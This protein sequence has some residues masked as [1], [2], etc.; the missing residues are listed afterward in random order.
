M[1]STRPRLRFL[2]SLGLCFALLGSA[3]MGGCMRQVKVNPLAWKHVKRGSLLVAK[4]Q[5]DRASAEYSLALEYNP[6]LPEALNGLGL[7][8]FH[9]GQMRLA[10]SFFTKAILLDDDFAEGHNNHGVVLLRVHETEAAV[11]SFRNAISVDPGY[12]NARFN[13]A[14]GL[15]RLGK[16]HKARFQLQKVIALDP[17]M[18]LA[19]AE[20]GCLEVY[21]GHR[22]AAGRQLAIALKLAGG[23]AAAH[24]CQGRLYRETGDLVQAETSHRLARKLDPSSSEALFE[25]GLTLALRGKS[26]EASAELSRLVAR[27]PR[28]AAAHF[29]HGY[30][31]AQLGQHAAAEKAFRSA[32]KLREDYPAAH[33]ALA[34]TLVSAGRAKD[35][36]KSYLAFMSRVP[37]ALTIHTSRVQSWLASHGKAARAKTELWR[38]H[39]TQ[40]PLRRSLQ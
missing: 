32:L 39:A 3:L 28:W 29:A 16:A 14:L 8:A 23:V 21:Q 31:M 27:Q 26:Q 4:K 17:K 10:L 40:A 36:K 20:L 1:I 11:R 35:A 34:D 25:L 9:R 30:L 33:L 38:S 5:L 19:R 15:L 12:V 13:L 18:A 2:Q 7:I 6:R 37:V 22:A 24:R